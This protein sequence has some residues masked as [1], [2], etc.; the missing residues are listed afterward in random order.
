MEVIEIEYGVIINL[1]TY[2]DFMVEG[3]E[4]DHILMDLVGLVMLGIV[5]H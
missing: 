3:R 2:Q 1:T 4:E 5:V